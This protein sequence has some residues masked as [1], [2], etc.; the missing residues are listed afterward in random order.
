MVRFFLVV[1][2]GLLAGI[3]LAQVTPSGP[4]FLFRARYVKG[5]SAKYEMKSDTKMQG[6]SAVITLML[7]EKVLSVKDGVGEIEISTGKSTTTI[8]GKPFGQPVAIDNKRRVIK[9]DN[10]GRSVGESGLAVQTHLTLPKQSVKVGDSWTSVGG[11]IFG[12]GQQQEVQTTYKFLG[13][14]TLAG[15]RA[16]KLAVTLK[17]RGTAEM[18]GSGTVWISAADCSLLRES[19]SMTATMQQI[20]A[21]IKLEL[22]R[23]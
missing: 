18:T 22:V 7:G 5:T 8:N 4:G 20:K 23:K 9:L 2:I 11:A 3:S 19:A 21:P 14:T 10:T 6:I 12:P 1:A 16:A 13:L 17:G 15:Q